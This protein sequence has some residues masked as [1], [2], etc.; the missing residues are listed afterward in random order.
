[1]A[2]VEVVVVSYNSRDRLRACVEPLS[3]L[4]WVDV[5]VVDNASADGSLQSIADLQVRRIARPDNGGFA[6]GCNEGWRSGTAPFV[7][8]LNPDATVDEDSLRRLVR[9]LEEHDRIGAVAPRIMHP[10][11]TIAFSLRRYPRLRST[12]ARAFFLHRLFPNAAW[13]DELVRDKAEYERPSSPEWVSGAAVVLPRSV[14]EE[15]NGWDEGFFLYS[16]DVDLCRRVWRSG[17]QVRFEP[18][19]AAVHEGGASDPAGATRPI[20]V[21]S[22]IRYA[23]K[24]RSRPYAVLERVGVG[25]EELIRLVVARGGLRARAAHARSLKLVVSRSRAA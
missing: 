25:L 16:E 22:R 10:D 9:V 5:V 21:A 4:D 7:C 8:F 19:A 23:E 18:A 11:G 13:S 6:V 12:Y 2:L 15:L 1:V 3:G 17:R 24:H 14:L 20:L